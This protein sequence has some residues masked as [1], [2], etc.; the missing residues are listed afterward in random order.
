MTLVEALKPTGKARL[1]SWDKNK[2]DASYI[3]FS[4]DCDS[5]L[6][7]KNYPFS[8]G[9]FPSY[10]LREDWLP[11]EEPKSPEQEFKDY[12]L[13]ELEE[14]KKM[15]SENRLVKIFGDKLDKECKHEPK[16]WAVP[17]HRNF[18]IEETCWHCDA[19]IKSEGWSKVE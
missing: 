1:P 8:F 16:N 5:F 4:S 13:K 11:Y 14:L 17:G 3:F 7:E 19:K 10:I 15:Y 9:H 6:T 2:L 18:L 12:V